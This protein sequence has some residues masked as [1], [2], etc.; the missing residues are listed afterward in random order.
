MRILYFII[1]SFI[2]SNYFSQSSCNNED[3]ESSSAGAVTVSTSVSGWTVT[4]GS[5]P[6]FG[7][8]C[9]HS[10]C[11]IGNPNAASII[12]AGAGYI[13]PN[14]GS[15]YPI[16]SVFGSVPNTGGA[17]G[18]N[19]IMVNDNTPNGS[20]QKISKSIT[21]TTSNYYLQLAFISVLGIGH[22]CCDAPSVSFR[23]LD[24]IGGNTV[25]PCPQ[26]T[27][28]VPGSMCTTTLAGLNYSP[29]PLNS[30]L[31]YNK[32]KTVGFD[33]SPFIGTTVTFEAI[34]NDCTQGNHQG[35]MYFD[36]QCGPMGLVLNGSTF[37]FPSA[38]NTVTLPVCGYA[39]AA[40]T[41][42][43]GFEP[44]AWFATPLG[45]T[46]T[47]P[48][49]TFTTQWTGTYTLTL[50][51]WGSCPPIFKYGQVESQSGANVGVMSSN[52]IICSG[53]S[54]TLTGNAANSYS[55]STGS[56]NTTIVVS[57]TASTIYTLTGYNNY[58]CTATTTVGITVSTC[59]SIDETFFI[60]NF[61]IYP[62]PAKDLVNILL[63]NFYE[64]RIKIKITDVTG[65]LIFYSELPVIDGKIQLEADQ[66]T[67]GFYT[68]Q[69]TNSQSQTTSK[70]LVIIK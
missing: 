15:S 43:P 34:A 16:Y 5:N 32:W 61:S 51:S 33:L 42:P 27:A 8:S 21:V 70:R 50:G 53:S 30:F 56:T 67:N 49:P 64:S 69:L 68:L 25:I 35:Y 54:A 1:F 6:F 41:A 24:P 28:C 18:N 40:V 17:F 12:N 4:G 48:S 20:A 66:F 58:S 47:P 14:I 46:Y 60:D 11:C 62:Q 23:L 7:G 9:T 59:T 37:Y 29:C 55:W 10:G 26:Y 19:I 45:F 3:F 36:A 57:P 63:S 22:G 38:I 65:K 31:S 39:Y 52:S 44:Y 2:I 13:D